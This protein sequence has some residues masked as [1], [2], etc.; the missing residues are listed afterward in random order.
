MLETAIV[1]AVIAA[2]LGAAAFAWSYRRF[3]TLRGRLITYLHTAAPEMTVVSLTDV[4]FSVQVLG[5]DI[6]VDLATLARTHPAGLTETQWFA[7]VIEGIRAQVPLPAA[8]P[9]PLVADRLMPLLKPSTYV[10]L[11]ERYPPALRLASRRFA[12]DVAVTYVI[13]A[14]D[15]R[16]AVTSAMLDAWGIGVEAL[17][18]RSVENLRKQT[19]HLLAELGGP[20]ARY[21]HIDGYDATRILVADLIVPSETRD[22]VVAIPEET[23]LFTAPRAEQ[24][25]LAAE[26]EEGHRA[27]ARPLT[28]VLF[29]LST[30]GPVPVR[31]TTNA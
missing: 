2:A 8:A 16:T 9:Y 28:P 17:H 1:L 3:H 22:P 5:T 27:S 11:F 23:V 19:A 6:D 29:S 26:A 15:R 7:S 25:A 18:A 24:I 12:S 4:G 21:E 14:A 20:R 10:A 30:T 31:P 13:A